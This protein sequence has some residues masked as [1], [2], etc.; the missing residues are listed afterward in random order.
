LSKDLYND[1]YDL[2]VQYNFEK[3]TESLLYGSNESRFYIMHV[4]SDLQLEA[5]SG[6]IL[7][8][9]K[10]TESSDLHAQTNNRNRSIY[11]YNEINFYIIILVQHF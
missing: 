8:T 4:Y 7:K 9:H 2:G 6:I 3:T 10:R 11:I 1:I 5:F